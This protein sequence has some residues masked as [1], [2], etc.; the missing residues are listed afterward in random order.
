MQD[1]LRKFDA[2]ELDAEQRAIYDVYAER[3][4]NASASANSPLV[5]LMD[6][7]GHLMGPT[8]A[9]LLNATIGKGLQDLGVAVRVGPRLEPR[10]QE[11]VILVV[12]QRLD[13][14]FERFAHGKIA[15]TV[16]LA[17]EVIDALLAGVP[18]TFDD[19]AEQC[20][21]DLVI[22]LMDNGSL[23]DADYS[24]ALDVFGE[25]RLFDLTAI[26]GWYQM[27]ALQLSVFQVM[28]PA[29]TVD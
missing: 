29:E 10:V 19:G 4:A 9:W 18:V 20:A 16:G 8:N 22:S 21:Y 27:I 25:G 14:T 2:A 7:Q 15:R 5:Q 28:P 17:D 12:A 1:R 23:S 6:E 3:H 26:V 24:R 11:I 13:S